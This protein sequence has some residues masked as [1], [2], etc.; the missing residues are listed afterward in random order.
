MIK[1]NPQVSTAAMAKELGI[2]IATVKENAQC[3]IYWQWLQWTL[4]KLKETMK[5]KLRQSKKSAVFFDLYGIE[6]SNTPSNSCKE[7]GKK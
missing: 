3:N 1:K 7:G 5:I 2:G 6:Q 4:E